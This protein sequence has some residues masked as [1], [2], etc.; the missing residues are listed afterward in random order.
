M[1]KGIT[2]GVFPP[3]PP[4]H[5]FLNFHGV[6]GSFSGLLQLVQGHIALQTKGTPA[7]LKEMHLEHTDDALIH[8]LQ[9]R[10]DVGRKK[11]ELDVRVEVI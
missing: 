5:V 2:D 6:L 1:L 4:Y 7:L 3:M 9:Q 8:R 10:H 11:H